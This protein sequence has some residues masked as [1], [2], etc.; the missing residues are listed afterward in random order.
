MTKKNA[1]R[2]QRICIVRHGYYPDDPRSRKQALALAEAGYLVEVLCLRDRGQLANEVVNGVRVHR[3]PVMHKRTTTWRYFFQY[4]LSFVLFSILLTLLHLRHRYRC[5]HVATMPD[6]LVFTTVFP[7]ALGA[8]VLLDLHEPTPEL[9]LTKYGTRL[10]T[11]LRLQTKIEQAAIAYSDATL[12]VTDELRARVIQR[13]APEKNIFIVRNVCDEQAFTGYMPPQK[14]PQDNRFRLVTHGSIEERYGHEEIIRA[15]AC[16]RDRIPNLHLQIVGSGEYASELDVLA[17]ALHCNDIVEF[18]G[19]VP[20]DELVRRLQAADAGV[21]AMRQTP[22]SEL[23]DTNKMYE[24]IVLRKPLIISRLAPVAAQF[25]D[26][27]MKFFKPGDH[28]DLARCILEVFR[29]PRRG[30]TLADNAR[31]RYETLRWAYG[32]KDYLR[33]IERLVA[34]E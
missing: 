16:L 12:T 2:P 29:D 13:G 4:G 8:K 14:V 17:K 10:Q 34:R 3:I 25:D 22:Y 6:F 15:V 28:E 11:L 9:W 27:C 24:Y 1:V 31:R 21:V 33:V 18:A 30:G 7:R 20:H 23:I 26:S 32:K 5:I 19:Y